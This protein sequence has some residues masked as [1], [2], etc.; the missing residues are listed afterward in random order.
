M[1]CSLNKDKGGGEGAA[2]QG[3]GEE[4]WNGKKVREEGGRRGGETTGEGKREGRTG[5]NQSNP[6]IGMLRKTVKCMLSLIDF[7]Q[8]YPNS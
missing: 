6:S 2:G 7:P 3:K 5:K 1:E 8:F 4:D